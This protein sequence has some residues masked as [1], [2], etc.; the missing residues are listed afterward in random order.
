M[1]DVVVVGAGLAGHCAALEAAANGAEVV[2]LEKMP[3]HGGSS[4]LSSGSFAF[5]CTD[6]QAALG[7]E[8][9]AQKMA[10]DI[11]KASGGKADPALVELFVRRQR[12]DYDWLKHKGVIFYQ[13]TLSSNQRVPRTHPTEP[14][15]MIDCL[16]RVV[17][18]QSNIVL[19][20]PYRGYGIACHGRPGG[21][22]A[23]GR[24]SRC[25]D[26]RAQ[27]SNPHGGRIFPQS[28]TDSTIRPAIGRGADAGGRRLLG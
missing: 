17:D 24:S 20:R 4:R 28:T 18:Q 1:T 15:Q 22:S 10:A 3:L 5:S 9:D 14:G 19:S 12:Q 27:S 16:H 2:M 8:D 6:E 26:P 7:I 13:L 21:R 11:V 23:D 25:A